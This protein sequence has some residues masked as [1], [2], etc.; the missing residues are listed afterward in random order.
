[1]KKILITGANSY[2]GVS[3][4]NHLKK[5]CD[6]YS[7]D[8]VDMINH[9]LCVRIKKKKKPQRDEADKKLVNMAK[10]MLMDRN[11][12]T[13]EEAYRYIQKNSMDFGRRM[14]ESAQMILTLYG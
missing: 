14:V 2:I 1:M 4:E 5:W 9:N 10:L 7:V 13:E 3:F 6:Q 8:T 11:G 12:L